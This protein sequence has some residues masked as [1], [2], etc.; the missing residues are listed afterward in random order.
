MHG[1]ILFMLFSEFR[2][3]IERRVDG[4]DVL[5]GIGGMATDAHVQIN[6]RSLYP[7]GRPRIERS[8]HIE[9]FLFGP[10]VAILSNDEGA[11][12]RRRHR[13]LLT[14]LEPETPITEAAAFRAPK[15]GRLDFRPEQYDAEA[16]GRWHTLEVELPDDRLTVSYIDGQ[17]DALIIGGRPAFNLPQL[18]IIA[19]LA[20]IK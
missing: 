5:R 9:T 10:V 15:L 12:G 7:Q 4:G 16:A 19:K 18:E 11:W 20:R 3:E 8:A 2:Q 17:P 14:S 6:A 13:A 1:T